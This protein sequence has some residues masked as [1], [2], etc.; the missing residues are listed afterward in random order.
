MYSKVKFSAGV[1]LEVPPKKRSSDQSKRSL[2]AHLAAWAA[3]AGPAL[4]ARAAEPDLPDLRTW[5]LLRDVAVPR[6]PSSNRLFS[7]APKFCDNLEFG[8]VQKEVAN[9]VDLKQICRNEYSPI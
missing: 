7:I 5:A 6:P 9:L 1:P 4:A 8:A 3:A 2:G